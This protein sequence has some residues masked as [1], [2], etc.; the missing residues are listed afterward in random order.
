MTVVPHSLTNLI[1]HLSQPQRLGTPG[2]RQAAAFDRLGQS[3]LAKTKSTTKLT[4]GMRYA[5]AH[6]LLNPALFNIFEAG[7]KGKTTS[8]MRISS[9]CHIDIPFLLFAA[10]R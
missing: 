3:E 6:H 1:I 4:N 8:T 5:I 9:Q 2:R 10:R 7:K